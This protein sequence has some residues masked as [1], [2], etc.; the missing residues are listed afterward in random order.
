MVKNPDFRDAANVA[1]ERIEGSII[2]DGITRVQAF[3]AGEIDTLD[4]GGLPPEEIERLKTEPYYE[5]YPALGTYFYG[6][7][8]ENVGL[9][10]RR[11]CPRHQ[12]EDH[13]RQID[14]TDRAQ[15]TGHDRGRQGLRGHQ[16]ELALASRRGRHDAGPGAHGPGA[17]RQDQDQPVPQRLARPQGD[18][19]RGAVN[20]AG[21]RHRD[22]HQG[23]GVGPV[24]R[25]P[26]P[27]A[28]QGG[29][30][31][32]PRVD[33]RLPGCDQ[34]LEL[35]TCDSGNNNTNWCNEEYDALVEEV[36]DTSTSA[37]YE[38]YRQ[39]EG[40]MFD[41]DGDVPLTPIMWYTYPNLEQDSV[42]DTFFI[43]PLDQI[44]FTKVVV[45][46]G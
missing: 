45:A 21:A 2:V 9:E 4:G 25:V 32:P 10:Q 3:E 20:V 41:E 17:G 11:R 46:G 14:R 39:L 16:P 13:L 37:R 15:A 28:E 40:I 12:P 8:V 36:R 34:R 33:L 7:N 30:R 29:R 22:H 23:A 26:R 24:P 38:I 27:A 1:L 5:Q 42:R 44:D 6:F 19:R 18:R 35:F 43:N 31:L